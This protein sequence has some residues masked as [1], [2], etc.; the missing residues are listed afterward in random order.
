MAAVFTGT[1]LG[2]FNSSYTQLGGASGGSGRL[3]QSNSRYYVNLASGNLVLQDIDETILTRGLPVSMLRT[4]NSQGTVAGQ[5][6]DGWMSGFERRVGNLT[7]TLNTAG[8][9]VT[10][11]LGDGSEVVYTWDASRAKVRMT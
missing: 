8:S 9:T 6:Q 4:Y 7:G 1:G 2:L 11:Y 5:G 10:R 3:G